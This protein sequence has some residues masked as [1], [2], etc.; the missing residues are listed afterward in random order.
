Q[1]MQRDFYYFGILFL[2]LYVIG[3]V[4]QSILFFQI[5]YEVYRLHSFANWFLVVVGTALVGFIYMLKYYH[6]Q[7][8]RAVFI[9]GIIVIVASLCQNVFFYAIVLRFIRELQPYYLF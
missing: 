8:Y 1:T 4:F 6:H 5:E 2:S 9:T 7:G 3:A